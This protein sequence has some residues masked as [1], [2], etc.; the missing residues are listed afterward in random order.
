MQFEL[1]A[2]QTNHTWTL[3]TLPPHETVIGC[4]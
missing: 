3:I 4:H 2:L 1:H